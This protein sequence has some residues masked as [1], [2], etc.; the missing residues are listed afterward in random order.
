MSITNPYAPGTANSKLFRIPA[1]LTLKSGRII[2]CAD[3]R[4]GN[5]TD[6]PANI[7]T[8]VRYSDDNAKTWSQV[9]F[10]NHFDDMEDA[11]HNEAIP[12]SASFIDA[13]ICEGADNEIYHVC[14]ACPAFM[15]LWS[16]G[17]VG[18]A[19]GYIDGKLALCDMTRYDDAESTA[20]DK[21]HYPYYIDNFNNE[22]FA[23]VLCFADNKS[24][25][26]Y[27][28]SKSYHLYKNE[29]EGYT[30]V[31]IKQ[32]NKDGTV[33]HRDIHANVFY[34][35]S[36]VKLYP[37]YYL[38]V[39]K[40]LDGG[41]TWGDGEII[42]TQINSTGFTGFAPGRGI[43]VKVNGKARVIFAVYDNNSHRE[44]TSAIYTDDGG[45][46][47]QRGEKANKVGMAGKSSESQFVLLN[48]NVLRMYSRNTAGFISYCDS[49][50]FGETWGE[51]TMD[52]ALKYCGNCMFSVINYSKK[53]Q[54]KDA[55]VIAYPGEAIRKCGVIKIGFYDENNVVT[56]KYRK[57]VTDDLIPFTY[58]YSCIT[59][60]S[61]GNILDLYESYKAEISLVKYSIADLS[62]NDKANL[63]LVKKIK[64]AYCN[65]TK[66]NIER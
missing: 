42:N 49:S 40:S 3:V 32:F 11:D 6:D 30:P 61:N 66:K 37:T 48:N 35:M 62:V 63:S 24:Y 39:K 57:N 34:A 2:A 8:A 52:K 44:F 7:E 59:E 12:S 65:A 54:G 28:V 15:G 31:T 46:T 55:I 50:D 27:Y 16:A 25:K 56:W 14:D 51:Y 23:P 38:W 20:L 21:K 33:S 1:I 22:G 45:K 19:N 18:K 58:V 17:T 4:Y 29:G 9:K 64:S 60:D 26:N 53:I 47:W 5:G 13:A 41:E 10:V 36:P 43:T